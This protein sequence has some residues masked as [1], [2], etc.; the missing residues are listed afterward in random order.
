MAKT[1]DEQL[2][3]LSQHMNRIGKEMMN[4]KDETYKLRGAELRVS[5]AMIREWASEI[6]GAADGLDSSE[7]AADETV[8]EETADQVEESE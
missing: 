5:G 2:E 6:K 3:T 4:H 1:I 7:Q 8:R